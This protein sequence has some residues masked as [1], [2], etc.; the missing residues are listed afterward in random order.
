MGTESARSTCSSGTCAAP[1]YRGAQDISVADDMWADESKSCFVHIFR[2]GEST[3]VLEHTL[4]ARVI[5][6]RRGAQRARRYVHYTNGDVMRQRAPCI[7]RRSG[8]GT[9]TERRI[10]TLARRATLVS[11]P[12]PTGRRAARAGRRRLRKRRLPAAEALH[13]LLMMKPAPRLRSFWRR[14]RLSSPFP[15]VLPPGT[16]AYTRL[17][18]VAVA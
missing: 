10:G 4:H 15:R 14:L 1:A 12:Q 16:P 9:R 11:S 18:L 5:Y 17:G 13:R 2:T 8:L 7:S 6:L 3:Q